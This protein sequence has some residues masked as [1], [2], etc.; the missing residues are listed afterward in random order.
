MKIRESVRQFSVL[1]L[2][3]IAHGCGR[4]DEAWRTGLADPDPSIRRAAVRAV[5]VLPDS[6]A[7]L[8][9]LL[10]DADPTV[11]LAAALSL[12]KIDPKNTVCRPVIAQALREGQGPTFVAVGAC[13]ASA[14]W[15]IP[16]LCHLL[17]DRRPSIRAL[18]AKTLAE[19]GTL[20]KEVESSLRRALSDESSAVRISVERSLQR[21]RA[22]DAPDVE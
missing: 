20:D 9:P 21:L 5:V 14:K 16:T 3:A 11:R 10:N 8:V 15:A 19:I 6:A 17:S 4:D 18:S 12:L 13:G 7:I 22:G 2:L 1:L